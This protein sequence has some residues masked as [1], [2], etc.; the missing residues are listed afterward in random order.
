LVEVL[1]ELSNPSH[2]VFVKLSENTASLLD[3]L[4]EDQTLLDLLQTWKNGILER[5]GLLEALQQLLA[6]A[7]ESENRRQEAVQWLANNIE[8]YRTRL[9]NDENIKKST[10]EMLKVML[11][12]VIISEHHLIGEIA[13]ETLDAFSNEKLIKFIDDKVGD[14]LQWIRINGSIV[15]AVAGIILYLFTNL[16]YN[17]Y[18]LPLIQK[19]T[20]LGG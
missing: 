13:R 5:L 18:L 14:D 12:K 17:P 2:P 16:L 4:D 10:E 9:K 19:L 1:E 3:H 20:G 8:H 11:Q 6:S 7:A 15:G